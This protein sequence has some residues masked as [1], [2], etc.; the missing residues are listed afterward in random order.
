MSLHGPSPTFLQGAGFDRSPEEESARTA[1]KRLANKYVAPD[2]GPDQ[3]AAD[4]DLA[5]CWEVVT[6]RASLPAHAISAATCRA[7]QD[8]ADEVVHGLVSETGPVSAKI[9]LLPTAAAAYITVWP[10]GGCWRVELLTP[11][12]GRRPSRSLIIAAANIA[13]A[14]VY[15]TDAAEGLQ[16]P[17]RLLKGGAE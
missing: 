1:A 2:G 16:K 8:L 5:E 4:P 12:E 3:P 17:L 13:D 14:V 15:G 11:C 6:A 10:T 7:A 9:I